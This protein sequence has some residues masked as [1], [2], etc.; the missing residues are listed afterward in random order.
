MQG[1]CWVESDAT[2]VHGGSWASALSPPLAR[3][4]LSQCPPV[5]GSSAFRQDQGPQSESEP[6]FQDES[7]VLG[8]WVLVGQQTGTHP[9]LGDGGHPWFP[10]LQLSQEVLFP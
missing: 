6:C 4:L 5:P 1:E 7:S 2:G 10:L 3:A 9:V 8:S